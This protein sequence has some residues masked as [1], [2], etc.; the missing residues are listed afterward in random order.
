MDISLP[1]SDK[2]I[3]AAEGDKHCLNVVHQYVINFAEKRIQ[4]EEYEQYES[5]ENLIKCCILTKDNLL[6]TLKKHQSMDPDHLSTI[7]HF[8]YLYSFCGVEMLALIKL[9]NASRIVAMSFC[10]PRSCRLQLSS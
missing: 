3:K 1:I 2:L 9:G 8:P 5:K 6:N 10:E 4:E 7:A